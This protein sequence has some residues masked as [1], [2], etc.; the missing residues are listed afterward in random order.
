MPD[1]NGNYQVGE[2]M[3]DN[4]D[5]WK[6]TFDGVLGGY[7]LYRL[8]P[9]GSREIQDRRAVFNQEEFDNLVG[10][11]KR[12]P[13]PVDVDGW[14]VWE[15]THPYYL[16]GQYLPPHIP[17]SSTV[18]V[19]SL[20]PVNQLQWAPEFREF[21][22]H[23]AHVL[24]IEHHGKHGANARQRRIETRDATLSEDDMLRN[25]NI[26]QVRE[27]VGHV[28]HEMGKWLEL[29]PTDDT[30]GWNTTELATIRLY[31]SKLRGA[32]GKRPSPRRLWSL[33]NARQWKA[34]YDKNI[35]FLPEPAG[36]PIGVFV[37]TARRHSTWEAGY[38][39]QNYE[40]AAHYRSDSEG[41]GHEASTYV[42]LPKAKQVPLGTTVDAS[43]RQSL[44]QYWVDQM[45]YLRRLD[46]VWLDPTSDDAVSLLQGYRRFAEM[47]WLATKIDSNWANDALAVK[48][49]TNRLDAE[50]YIDLSSNPVLDR[51]G[52]TDSES[53]WRR[54]Y[55]VYDTGANT[56]TRDA[57]DVDADDPSTSPESVDHSTGDDRLTNV[58]VVPADRIDRRLAAAQSARDN[59]WLDEADAIAEMEGWFGKYGD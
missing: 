48:M 4:P 54:G 39:L 44:Q 56:L 35:R 30:T 32:A 25:G 42:A 20:F 57:R 23:F 6:F 46:E 53:A 49:T 14:I 7:I 19:S 8:H 31:V 45:F 43:R 2:F 12:D 38:D 15:Y 21:L 17:G 13:S 40:R 51:W 47:N 55:F 11:A 22:A 52:G 5:D 16:N 9:S 29:D 27:M 24:D 36:R 1:V 18:P 28:W 26:S 34:V 50:D 33:H 41:L 37:P 10:Y 3:S 59:P 58:V